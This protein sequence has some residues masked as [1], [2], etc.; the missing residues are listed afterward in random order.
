LATIAGG[1]FIIAIV[2]GLAAP[3]LELTSLVKPIDALDRCC[4]LRPAW[5]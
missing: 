2:V 5:R 4:R 3:L 1:L